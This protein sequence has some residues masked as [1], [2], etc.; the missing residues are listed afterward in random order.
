MAGLIEFK[1]RLGKDEAFDGKFRGLIVDDVVKV[2]AQEGFQFTADEI[3]ELSDVP[4]A[5]LGRITG[6]IHNP[7]FPL[8]NE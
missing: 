3:E 6:G 4:K 1:E 2:A 7:I 8:P 5:F